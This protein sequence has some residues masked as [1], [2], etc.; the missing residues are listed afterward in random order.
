MR[1]MRVKVIHIDQDRYD[2]FWGLGWNN[3]SRVQIVV[4]P[5]VK[6]KFVHLSGFVLPF[7]AR[8]ATSKY[9]RLPN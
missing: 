8:I 3:H 7:H 1:D 4:K 2:I 9:L 5:D 6:P